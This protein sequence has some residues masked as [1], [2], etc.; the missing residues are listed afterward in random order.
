LCPSDWNWLLCTVLTECSCALNAFHSDL[1]T[2]TLVLPAK[3]IQLNIV[4][5]LETFVPGSSVLLQ[6]QQKKHVPYEDYSVI[7]WSAWKVGKRKMHALK[8]T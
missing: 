6:E 7:V 1:T 2:V 4:Q 5:P 3:P 8:K